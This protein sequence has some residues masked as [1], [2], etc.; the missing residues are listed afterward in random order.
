VSRGTIHLLAGGRASIR[1]GRDPLLTQVLAE[2][3]SLAY[4]GAASEDNRTF[5]TMISTYLKSCG[6]GR[7]T[8][9]P[10]AGRKGDPAKAR[11]ILE[12]A[13]LVFVSGGDVEAGMAVLEARGMCDFLRD[14]CA[15]G[16]PI[17]G[18]SAGSVMIGSQWVRWEDPDDDASACLFPCL[19]LAPLAC[20]THA[21]G[22]GWEELRVFLSLGPDGSIAYGI[23]SGGAL[24]VRP[25][26]RLEALG[27]PIC[28][29]ARRKGV[30][31]REDDL[32]LQDGRS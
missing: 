19:G 16:K 8:L 20:D 32:E 30:V 26:G 1:A 15:A 12:S 9:V 14:L 13:D 22:D 6:A 18:L 17:L 4:V 23:P 21:E 10:L 3:P 7:I 27:A 11:A 29:F 28:R 25:D 24:R 2:H 31:R 5:F